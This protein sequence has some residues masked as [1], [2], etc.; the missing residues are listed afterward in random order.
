MPLACGRVDADAFFLAGALGA[1]VHLERD[2][3]WVAA[4]A[5]GAR[6]VGR[7]LA[8]ARIARAAELGA[9]SERR[10]AG[11]PTRFDGRWIGFDLAPSRRKR[12]CPVRERCGLRRLLHLPRRT[13]RRTLR[14][15]VGAK[16]PGWD[17][18]AGPPTWFKVAFFAELRRDPFGPASLGLMLQLAFAVLTICM[19]PG[20]ARRFGHAYRCS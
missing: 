20:I 11:T 4:I 6:P 19:V 8:V 14:V 12:P 17:Q 2:H 10:R 15:R 7:F 16:R 5:G 18:G 1:F 13:V 9:S 3:M